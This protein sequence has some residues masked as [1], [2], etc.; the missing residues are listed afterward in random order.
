MGD[1]RTGIEKYRAKLKS[2]GAKKVGTYIANRLYAGFNLDTLKFDGIGILTYGSNNGQYN[3]SN[4]P[5]TSNYEIH[6]YT[7]IGKLI[8]YSGSL[9]LNRIVRKG[10][11]FL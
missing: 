1:V 4:Y 10:L 5:V 2:L 6:Q 3:G 7:S 8:G 9:E 11:D